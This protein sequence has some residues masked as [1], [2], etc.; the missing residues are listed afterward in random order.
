MTIYKFLW[1]NKVNGNFSIIFLY[2]CMQL[3]CVQSYYIIILFNSEINYIKNIF[4]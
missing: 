3:S 4:K 1:Y 2:N